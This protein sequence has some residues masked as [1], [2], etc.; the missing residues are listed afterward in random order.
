MVLEQPEPFFAVGQW[1]VR[2]GQTSDADVVALL[3]REREARPKSPGNGS[4]QDG[5]PEIPARGIG[6]RLRRAGMTTGS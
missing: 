1:Y 4:Q 5:T 2:F 3:E 6:E